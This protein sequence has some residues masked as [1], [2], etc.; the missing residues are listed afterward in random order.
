VNNP[1]VSIVIATMGRTS[2]LDA[3]L[4][5]VRNNTL[6]SH[7][8]VL[9]LPKTVCLPTTL[10]NKYNPRLIFEDSS[11]GCV[12]A[13]NLGFRNAYGRFLVHINDDCEVLPSW[14]DNMMRA[15]GEK[16]ALGAFAFMEPDTNGE[17]VARSIWGRPYA[18]FGFSKKELFEKL[19]YWSSDFLHYGADPDMGLKFWHAGYPVIPVMDAKVIHHCVVDD[20]RKEHLREPAS[21]M[22]QKKW[23]GIFW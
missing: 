16:D 12:A 1:L 15:I 3:C 6:I 14:L 9:V 23:R 11:S 21:N 4:E 5:S 8:V 19:G 22:L 7:E 13:Y 10:F 2:S 20:A 17:F 18:N